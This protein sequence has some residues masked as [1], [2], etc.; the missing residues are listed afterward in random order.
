SATKPAESGFISLGWKP[1]KVEN[2]TGPGK[3]LPYVWVDSGDEHRLVTFLGAC[4]EN[5]D[6]RVDPAMYYKLR[7]QLGTF[8]DTGPMV[9]FPWSGALFTNFFAH[10][11]LNYAAMGADNPAAFGATHRARVDWWENARRAVRLHQLKARTNPDWLATHGQHG[12]G[13][14][15]S[16]T[17]EGYG[18]PGVFPDRLAMP[19]ARPEF[20]Y[21][22]FNVK[23][24]FGGGTLAPYASG[25]SILFDPLS[26]LAAMKHNQSLK[27]P[28]GT[29]L[30]WRAPDA[31]SR[32]YGFQDAFNLGKNWVGTDCVAIDQGP[33][34]L[35]IENARSGMIWDLFH[36]HASVKA[37][38]ERLKLNIR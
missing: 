28:D 17:P 18:V 20:D 3:L 32:G 6:Y 35:C 37:G 36:R 23:D 29:P 7:R 34:L 1:D 19:D 22:T 10:C 8:G 14:S 12:W 30:V 38:L 26:A 21:S 31:Q 13:L 16:D 4:A 24:D 11:W 2:P 5:P 27:K 9:W 33:L 25:C 15:A